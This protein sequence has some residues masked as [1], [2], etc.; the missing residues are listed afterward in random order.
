MTRR[1]C[2]LLLLV[3]LLAT[4][5]RVPV[6]DELKIEPDKDGDTV[7]V[8]ASSTLMEN[9]PNDYLRSRVD[10]ARAAVLS[11]TDP[12][13][14]RFARLT[15]PEEEW[16]TY[17][18][19]RGTLQRVVRSARMPADD[20]QHLL[21]DTNITVDVVRGEGW[22]EIAFYPGSGGRA[23]REQQK[24]FD[25]ALNTWAQ[26]VAR[27]FT[28]VH[29]LYSYLQQAPG[30]DEYV[31]AALVTDDVDEALVTDEER[32]L[33]EAVVDA[34][35]DIATKMDEYEGHTATLAEEADL[36]FNP[37]P[38]RVV[39]NVPGDVIASEGFVKGKELVIEPV[40]LFS[41]I[42]ALEG[43][44]ISPDPLAALLRDDPKP[45]AEEL[46][47]MPRKSVSV[48]SSTEIA[49]AIREKLARPKAYSVRWRG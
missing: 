13:S 2:C 5:A 15:T 34:M 19:S 49:A 1:L 32:P 22:R 21:S 48:V 24:E 42:G 4:C 39:I 26:S 28:A 7:V 17:Q 46:A 6:T 11:N 16:V 41:A 14:I 36:V 44:W 12:W 35:G 29:H 27:Y 31:F 45:T 18:K 10:A 20:L 47:S 9:P 30:R 43:R 8:T 37:F 3:L 23:T 40:D 33:V 25:A 38:A